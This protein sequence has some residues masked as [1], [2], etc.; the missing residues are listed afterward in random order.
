MQTPIISAV[1]RTMAVSH[2][3]KAPSAMA[4]HKPVY[5]PIWAAR[6]RILAILPNDD[7]DSYELANESNTASA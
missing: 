1:H 6:S 5:H 4:P 3:L 7:D 2:A